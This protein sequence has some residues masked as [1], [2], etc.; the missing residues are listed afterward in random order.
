MGI[1]LRDICW[2]THRPPPP[3]T[4]PGSL[5]TDRPTRRPPRFGSTKVG[6]S[7]PPP[8]TAPKTV[9]HP[10]GSHIGW[11]WPPW[12]AWRVRSGRA[13]RFVCCH[14]PMSSSVGQP[15][16]LGGRILWLANSVWASAHCR[17]PQPTR[18]PLI[19]GQR[20]PM[21]KP[22]CRI[23]CGTSAAKLLLPEATT[24]AKPLGWLEGS[25]WDYSRHWSSGFAIP[26]I[27]AG[28]LTV[29]AVCRDH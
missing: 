6:G 20:K 28:I 25:V 1:I 9:A 11:R 19:Q 23:P 18:L 13:L 26:Q 7:P 27:A 15:E 29:G 12:S 10:S 2:G 17:R 3:P 14:G 22:V 24:H 8:L 5:A 4:P 16:V 21:G